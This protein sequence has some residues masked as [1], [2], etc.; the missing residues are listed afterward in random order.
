MKKILAIIL[1]VALFTIMLSGCYET[2]DSMFAS[3]RFLIVKTDK[4][5]TETIVVDSETGVL[6][7]VVMSGYKMGITVLYN[8]DGSVMTYD[9]K[10]DPLRIISKKGD[11]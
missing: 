7:L 6:Y 9:I 1:V 8:T 3:E 5:N 4:T 11:H 2:G 10:E